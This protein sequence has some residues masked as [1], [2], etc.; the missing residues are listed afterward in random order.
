M[1][2]MSHTCPVCNYTYKHPS[3]LSRHSRDKHGE[4][5]PASASAPASHQYIYLLR[6]R[7]FI[8]NNQDVY[9]IGRTHQELTKRFNKYPK[10]SQLILHIACLDSIK[11]EGELLKKFRAKFIQRTDIGSE[12][13][14]GSVEEMKDLIYMYDKQYQAE[15]SGSIRKTEPY[16]APVPAPAPAPAVENNLT[17]QRTLADAM[18]VAKLLQSISTNDNHQPLSI[19]GGTFKSFAQDQYGSAKWF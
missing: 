8:N 1:Y 6:E 19:M 12:Y 5:A 10:G 11:A 4:I 13:F 16:S 2:T 15:T 9:K 7:E 17:S 3:G 14:E 18:S